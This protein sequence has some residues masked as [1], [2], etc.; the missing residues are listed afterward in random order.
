MMETIQ[1]LTEQLTALADT[2]EH[3]TN[4]NVLRLAAL[5]IEMQTQAL[6]DTRTELA[7]EE[8][9]R[10]RLEG[11]L[12]QAQQAIEA[13]LQAVRYGHRAPIDV[14]RDMSGHINLMAGHGDP[15]Y[16]NKSGNSIRHVDLR[17]KPQ[18]KKAVTP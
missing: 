15:D 3:A 7:E 6:E 10:V 16:L 12:H 14:S 9:E 18:R 13:A 5:H 17:E 2:T 4:A 8:A 11:V 1:D